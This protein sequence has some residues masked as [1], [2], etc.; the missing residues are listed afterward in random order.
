MIPLAIGAALAAVTLAGCGAPDATIADPTTTAAPAPAS[1]TAPAPGTTVGRTTTTTSAK[2]GTPPPAGEPLPAMNV[3][4]VPFD[5]WPD[6]CSFITD[7]Q[8]KAFVPNATSVTHKGAAGA[9]Q[10]GGNTPNATECTYRAAVPGNATQGKLEISIGRIGTDYKPGF[11]QLMAGAVDRGD[12]YDFSA[13]AGGPAYGAGPSVKLYKS[14]Y[15][16]RFTSSDE[17]IAAAGSNRSREATEASPL[18]AI[19]L[20][21]AARIPG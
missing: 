19:M 13:R 6:A 9:I 1:T 14:G 15:D 12:E 3:E 2:A 10:G 4:G 16:L 18:A 7:D 21:V 17:K 5:Q 8:V 11:D 20:F